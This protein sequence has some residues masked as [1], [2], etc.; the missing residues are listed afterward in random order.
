[1]L[2]GT[3]SLFFNSEMCPFYKKET[4]VEKFVE[5]TEAVLSDSKCHLLSTE[6]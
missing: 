5:I 3:L 1:M 4:E 6:P 2:T